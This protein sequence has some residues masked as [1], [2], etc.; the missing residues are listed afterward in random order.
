MPVYVYRC[1]DGRE[2]QCP[3]IEQV[4][5]MSQIPRMVDCPVCGA[6]A[7]R[8]FTV[9]YLTTQPHHLREENRLRRPGQSEKD[10]LAQKK[11]DEKAYWERWDKQGIPSKDELQPVSLETI[12]SEQQR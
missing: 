11:A 12:L 6:A 3:D 1:T 5:P 7:K 8:I 2:P 4:F 9:P 10:Y